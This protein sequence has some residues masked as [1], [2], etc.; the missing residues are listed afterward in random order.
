MGVGDG[1]AAFQLRARGSDTR[2]WTLCVACKIGRA[3]AWIALHVRSKA[4]W[5]VPSVMG[6]AKMEFSV[7]EMYREDGV[8]SA[9][10]S[11]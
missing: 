7:G 10:K 11:R 2:R 1:G 6:S 9:K 3:S 5:C 8:G 4:V